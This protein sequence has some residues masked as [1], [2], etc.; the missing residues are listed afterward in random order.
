LALTRLGVYQITALIGEGGKG[1]VCRRP[2]H[3]KH[4]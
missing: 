2:R 3:R 4:V 1:Q